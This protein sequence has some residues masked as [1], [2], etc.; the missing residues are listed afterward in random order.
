LKRKRHVFK[1]FLVKYFRLSP[2]PAEFHSGVIH[3]DNLNSNFRGILKFSEWYVALDGPGTWKIAL[4]FDRYLSICSAGNRMINHK[5]LTTSERCARCLLAAWNT[6][7][8]SDLDVALRQAA[9]IDEAGLST[10]EIERMELVQEIACNIR[11]W[12]RGIRWNKRTDL[13][14]HLEL[15][16]HLASGPGAAGNLEPWTPHPQ[17]TDIPTEDLRLEML[18]CDQRS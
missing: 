9:V 13:N 17:S 7:N 18:A 14:T 10:S 11:M 4:N 5:S 8:L 16:R 1:S 15:L 12:L 6:G 2:N 3:V